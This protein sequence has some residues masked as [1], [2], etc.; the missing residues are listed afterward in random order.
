MPL[1]SQ[2]ELSRPMK[3]RDC[4]LNDPSK[5]TQTA[6]VGRSTLWYIGT[7]PP[8]PQSAAVRLRVISSISV[9]RCRTVAWMTPV[10]TNHRN[11]V[12]QWLQFIDVRGVGPGQDRRQRDATAINDQMVFAPRFGSICGFG[13]VF[14]PPP[15]ARA[16]ELST[17]ARDQSM[18]SAA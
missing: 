13:P 3:P 4:S 10:A 6:P 16:E 15:K 14:S 9:Q 11:R 18:R 5:P 1:G 12:H 7:D 8:P 17:I 2:P